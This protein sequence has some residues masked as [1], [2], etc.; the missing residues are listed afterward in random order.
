M[1]MGLILVYC[2]AKYKKEQLYLVNQTTYSVEI[3]AMAIKNIDCLCDNFI[4]H[5]MVWKIRR[6]NVNGLFKVNFIRVYGT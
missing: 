6:F 4:F 2:P 5:N 3:L 1:N